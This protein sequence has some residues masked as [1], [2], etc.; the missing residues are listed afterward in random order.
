MAIETLLVVSD[1]KQVYSLIK[2]LFEKDGIFNVIHTANSEEEADKVLKQETIT[3]VISDYDLKQKSTG[4]RLVERWRKEYPSIRAAFI[5]TG[6]APTGIAET[7][8]VDAVIQKTSRDWRD[9]IKR[10]LLSING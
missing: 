2:K 5:L 4:N 8:G 6:G 9:R 1:D 7:E 3:V 10:I